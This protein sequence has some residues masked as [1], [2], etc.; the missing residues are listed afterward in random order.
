MCVF[1]LGS[2]VKNISY[3]NGSQKIWKKVPLG[4]LHVYTAWQAEI[5][6]KIAL[7]IIAWNGVGED[8]HW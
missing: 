4:L 6:L 7:F 1:V 3:E 5:Y 2:N 8:S